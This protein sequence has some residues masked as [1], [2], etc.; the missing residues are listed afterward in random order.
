MRLLQAINGKAG[1]VGASER[2]EAIPLVVNRPEQLNRMAVEP[3]K[4]VFRQRP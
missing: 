1:P 3:S 4:T 2:E